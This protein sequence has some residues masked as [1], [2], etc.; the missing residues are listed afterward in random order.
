MDSEYDDVPEHEWVRVQR[1]SDGAERGAYRALREQF[2]VRCLAARLPCH[3]CNE[4][5]DW[6]ARHGSPAAFEVDHLEPVAVAPEREFDLSNWLPA[7]ALC[8]RRRGAA[9]ITVSDCGIP[10][11]DW[12][13]L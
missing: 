3:F 6:A 10:S 13:A 4:P 1:R 11:E 8:N 2:R 5:I 7:H 9:D 12:D